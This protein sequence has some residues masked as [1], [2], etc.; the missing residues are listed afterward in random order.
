[1][2]DHCSGSI[3][4]EIPACLRPGRFRDGAGV[5]RS[6]PL[7]WAF[8]GQ[9]AGG[10]IHLPT[11]SNTI[12]SEPTNI[13]KTNIGTLMGPHQKCGP[14]GVLLNHNFLFMQIASTCCRSQRHRR[15]SSSRPSSPPKTASFPGAGAS[16]RHG[17][18]PPGPCC[19]PRA[20]VVFR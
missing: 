13:D 16:R 15:Q 14:D 17:C 6:L 10:Q 12:N 5:L 19:V 4:Q 2:L 9:T 1:M 7:R 8:A 11:V 18:K 3:R 20:R